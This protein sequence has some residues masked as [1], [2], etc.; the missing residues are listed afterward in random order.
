[1]SVV[2]LL[3]G[4]DVGTATAS[5]V[6]AFGEAWWPEGVPYCYAASGPGRARPWVWPEAWEVHD[7]PGRSGLYPESGTSWHGAGMILFGAPVAQHMAWSRHEGTGPA[8][9]LAVDALA[10]W[11]SRQ[12][13][14][15]PPQLLVGG[16]GRRPADGPPLARLHTV[17]SVDAAPDGTR[18]A[19]LGWPVAV[20]HVEPWRLDLLMHHARTRQCGLLRF[21]NFPEVG[22]GILAATEHAPVGLCPVAA[23][24]QEWPHDPDLDARDALDARACEEV[25]S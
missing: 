4:S 9:P 20:A 2:M 5:L 19:A 15:L 17:P 22:G 24:T 25:A 21:Y 3:H 8:D 14:A 23:W 6:D 10:R 16:V 13:Q 12:V 11:Q 7:L 1:M 18:G